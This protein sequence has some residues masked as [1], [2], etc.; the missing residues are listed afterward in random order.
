MLAVFLSSIFSTASNRVSGGN[1]SISS[2]FTKSGS[3]R[4][5]SKSSKRFGWFVILVS[6][7]VSQLIQKKT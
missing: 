3:I 5:P 4:T 2:T 7:S 6:T 1:A